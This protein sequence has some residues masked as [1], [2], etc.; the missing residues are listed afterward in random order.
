MDD[1]ETVISEIAYLEE[2]LSDPSSSASHDEFM[3]LMRAAIQLE[4]AKRVHW[5]NV[6]D[7]ALRVAT[8]ESQMEAMRHAMMATRRVHPVVVYVPGVPSQLAGSAQHSPARQKFPKSLVVFYS[9]GLVCSVGFA[10]LLAMS[11]FGTNLIHPFL[12]LLGF[13]G[14]IGWLTTAWSDL[15]S[16]KAGKSWSQTIT[17]SASEHQ[18]EPASEP[19]S[20]I[21]GTGS[22]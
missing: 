20:K 16:L 13:V 7:V 14:G 3:K 2:G 10:V 4:M 5:P 6:D 9:L 1:D 19:Q 21:V 15:L 17:L 11:A 22:R 18:R 8:L 12:A